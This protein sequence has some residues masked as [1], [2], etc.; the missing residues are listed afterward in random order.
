MT[1]EKLRQQPIHQNN[2]LTLTNHMQGSHGVCS[3]PMS[4]TYCNH[5]FGSNTHDPALTSAS[6]VLMQVHEPT[7]IQRTC[8]EH[9]YVKPICL[10]H[11]PSTFQLAN[12]S[13]FRANPIIVALSQLITT[14]SCSS[15]PTCL[16]R[17]GWVKPQDVTGVATM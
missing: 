1:C 7:Y 11:F 4:L 15:L 10:S 12:R 8:T 13:H 3:K 16:S 5:A 14:S 6:C 17:L 2:D 9:C